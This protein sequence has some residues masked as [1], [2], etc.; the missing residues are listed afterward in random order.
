MQFFLEQYAR[1]RDQGLDY[2][3]A[4][5]M[6][7]A[8]YH[9][10]TAA[11][12]LLEAARRS[13]PALARARR[14]KALALRD[15]ALK[16]TSAAQAS[17]PAS[18][19]DR[20][21][22][23]DEKSEDEGLTSETRWLLSEKPNIRFSQIAGL[24]DVKE[25]INLAAVYPFRHP[26]AAEKLRVKAGGG[27]LL[28]GPPGTGK[29]MIAKAVATE[30]DAQFLSVKC[31]TI[32]SQWVGVA[33]RNIARLFDVARRYPV[34]VVFLD[35]SEALIGRRGGQSTVMNRV[36]PEFLSQIDGVEGSKNAILLLGATNRP[37]DMDE[38]ALRTG[39]FGEKVY[40]GLPDR[41]AREQIL[42]L[43]L[44]GIPLAPVDFGGL[45]DALD[46]YSGADVVGVCQKAT[47]LVMLRH[48]RSADEIVVTVEDLDRARRETPPSVTPAM[49]ARYRR[50]AETS[51]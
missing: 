12:Y 26:E 3:R 4:G 10:L 17:R 18:A 32:M 23:T 15:L 11:K 8:R 42:H 37:W 43:N 1:N 48:A 46:G 2:H 41:A 38:A 33:E 34:V 24:E 30:I 31:S 50:F 35:E 39:R 9:L 49:L 25:A 29:T 13:E 14:E 7:E 22:S 51:A 47:R 28:Y 5:Q 44:D 6:G 40:V 20:G 21:A 45:A 27:V 19:S 16:I 36:I